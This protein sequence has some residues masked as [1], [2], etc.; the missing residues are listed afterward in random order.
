MIKANQ[1]NY[2]FAN[3]LGTEFGWGN[4]P[5][6]SMLLIVLMCDA[7]QSLFGIKAMFDMLLS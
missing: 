5:L 6:L 2:L 4:E 7:M 3:G 1:F